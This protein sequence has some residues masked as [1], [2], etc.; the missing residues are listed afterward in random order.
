MGFLEEKLKNFKGDE[1]PVRTV[2]F[3][4]DKFINEI[5]E[6][7]GPWAQLGKNEEGENLTLVDSQAVQNKK[8]DLLLEGNKAILTYLQEKLK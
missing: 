3:Y 2:L 7:L 5:R 4:M 8:L 1:Q 6:Q